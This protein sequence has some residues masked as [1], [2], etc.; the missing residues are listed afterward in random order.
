MLIGI[1]V[2]EDLGKR[3]TPSAHFPGCLRMGIGANGH[4]GQMDFLGKGVGLPQVPYA[5]FP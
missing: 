5:H 3:D 2:N 1:K 4:L